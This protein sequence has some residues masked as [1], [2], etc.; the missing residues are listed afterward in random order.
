MD[1]TCKWVS[2]LCAIMY[3]SSWR[4]IIRLGVCLRLCLDERTKSADMQLSWINARGV[5]TRASVV[6]MVGSIVSK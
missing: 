2:V 1:E 6:V 5:S 3:D 4:F